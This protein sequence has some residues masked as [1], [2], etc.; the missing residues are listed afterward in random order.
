MAY[1]R[2]SKAGKWFCCFQSL[3]VAY[4]AHEHD[5]D[6]CHKSRWESAQNMQ[7]PSGKTS[8]AR[9]HWLIKKLST[10]VS[11]DEGADIGKS[12]L[13]AVTPGGSTKLGVAIAWE[14][15]ENHDRIFTYSNPQ[16]VMLNIQLSNVLL[17]PMCSDKWP[18]IRIVL[19]CKSMWCC[20][21]PLA[22]HLWRKSCLLRNTHYR[23]WLESKDWTDWK[24]IHE[25]G[26]DEEW[27]FSDTAL[28]RRWWRRDGIIS[29]QD[30]HTYI[31]HPFIH[32]CP[33]NA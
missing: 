16:I 29:I 5:V 19:F 18:F 7:L 22:V 23:V 4:F 14:C 21:L 9:R 1:I 26:A 12:D 32:T 6:H 30:C 10:S 15:I 28:W 13:G 11:I 8:C 24:S 2:S 3:P 33:F 17:L 31:S 27:N 25:R 20:R